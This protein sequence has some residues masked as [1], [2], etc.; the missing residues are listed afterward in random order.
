MPRPP[1]AARRARGD[2]GA[3]HLVQHGRHRIARG[4]RAR[5][6]LSLREGN[7]CAGVPGSVARRDVRK[8]LWDWY[9]VALWMCRT[10]KLKSLPGRTLCRRHVRRVDL[11]IVAERAPGDRF[12]KRLR[13]VPV[14]ELNLSFRSP[15]SRQILNSSGCL[16]SSRNRLITAREGQLLLARSA[17]T[18]CGSPGDSGPPPLGIGQAC[19]GNAAKLLLCRARLRQNEL[20]ARVRV[21]AARFW[22]ERHFVTFDAS[23]PER[24]QPSFHTRM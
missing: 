22:V 18:R 9:E 3:D 14:V 10:E 23:I 16:S 5:G 13:S 4:P 1:S 11:L 7:V 8:P 12:A 21:S 20:I 24:P 15:G 17:R 6:D 2:G 19:G